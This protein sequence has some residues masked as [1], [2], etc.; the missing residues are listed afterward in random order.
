M[1][2][3]TNPMLRKSYEEIKMMLGAIIDWSA[4]DADTDFTSPTMLAAVPDTFDSR[5]QWPNCVH[6]IRDQQSCGSC[7]AFAGSEVLSD[8]FCI[9]SGGTTNLVLS[10]QDLVSCDK[11]NFG[12]NGGNLASEWK[13]MINKGIVTDSCFS[14]HSGAGTSYPCATKC[15]DGSAFTKYH[16]AS[17]VKAST[18]K[19]IKSEIYANGPMETGFDVYADFMNY[20]SGVYHHVSGRLE[21][22]H[23]VK[24]VGWGTEGGEDY[25]LCANSWNT[26]WGLDGFFKIRQGDC[27]IDRAVYAGIPDTKRA[28][29]F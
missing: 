5:T 13:Y 17:T 16:A 12:C 23:A 26:D 20:A 19:A 24:I 8:R 25:W 2:M 7:W 21:G 14:Y 18:V 27:N 1:D 4:L 6:P 15:E 11:T 10:P 28:E 3:E 22:G 29:L 9:A